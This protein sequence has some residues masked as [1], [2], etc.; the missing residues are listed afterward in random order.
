MII[1]NN[2]NNSSNKLI[3]NLYI[4]TYKM[5]GQLILNYSSYF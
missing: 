4:V 2:N 1:N 3:S 5:S